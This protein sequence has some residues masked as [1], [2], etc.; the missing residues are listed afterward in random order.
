MKVANEFLSYTA[1]YKLKG[2]V[3]TVKR[4]LDDRTKAMYV[5]RKCS[6]VQKIAEE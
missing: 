5:R 4:T 3:L 6:R 2:N 1:T